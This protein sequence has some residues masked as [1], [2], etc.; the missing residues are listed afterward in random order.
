MDL[1]P[2]TVPDVRARG[3]DLLGRGHVSGVD[4]EVSVHE[5]TRSDR[6]VRAAEPD[7]RLI[8]ER[9]RADVGS[10]GECLGPAR[11]LGRKRRARRGWLAAAE[12]GVF[13]EEKEKRRL[14]R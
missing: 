13:V 14:A 11:I 6:L 10:S 1:D 2:A 9:R 5:V 12:R 7:A 3:G 8:G 4:E